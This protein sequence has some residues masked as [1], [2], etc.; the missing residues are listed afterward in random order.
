MPGESKSAGISEMR[1][2]L[3]TF[4]TLLSLTVP[5][6]A[7]QGDPAAVDS[8]VQASTDTSLAMDRRRD[9]LKD[10]IERDRTGRALHALARLRLE[11]GTTYSRQQ[12]RSLLKRALEREPDNAEYVATFAELL[13]RTGPRSGAYKRAREA[14]ALD[15]ENVRA[16]YWAGR[17][18]VWSW[19][20]TFFTREGAS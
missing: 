13:W 11:K 19:E 2:I 5:A 7:A 12:A 20:M 1:M 14:I 17:F 10:A 9:L 3:S 4:V 6:Q 8:L 18:V 15:P 16:H